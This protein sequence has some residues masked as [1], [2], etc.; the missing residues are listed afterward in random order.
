MPNKSIVCNAVYTYCL[1]IFQSAIYNSNIDRK[2]IKIGIYLLY[3]ML[4]M[5]IGKEMV[6]YKTFMRKS[7]AFLHNSVSKNKQ[8]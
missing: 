8:Q 1:H 4:K 3:T 5:H 6:F 7:N 2:R